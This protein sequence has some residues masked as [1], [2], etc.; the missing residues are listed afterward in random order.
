[1]TRLR[2][3][4]GSPVDVIVGRSAWQSGVLERARPA[5][6]DDV[7]VPVAQAADLVLLKLFAGG[8][9]D[10][11]DVAQLLGGDDA[12]AIATEVEH[13]LPALPAESARLWAQ[14]RRPS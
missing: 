5:T 14:V 2:P 4:D 10:F 9:Q 7:V 13:R 1:M 8:F 3:A 6:V 12:S 11:W